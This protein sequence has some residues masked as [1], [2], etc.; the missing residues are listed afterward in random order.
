[1]FASGLCQSFRALYLLFSARNLVVIQ[2][3]KCIVRERALQV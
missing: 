2:D 1:M 3:L